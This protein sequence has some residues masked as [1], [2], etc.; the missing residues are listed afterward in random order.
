MDT[1]FDTLPREDTSTIGIP[2]SAVVPL[3]VLVSV[4]LAS[5]TAVIIIL[6]RDR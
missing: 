1:S 3:I 2:K 6:S 4:S 5:L